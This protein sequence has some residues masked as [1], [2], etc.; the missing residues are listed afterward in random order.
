M[1]LLYRLKPEKDRVLGPVCLLLSSA[2]V[3]PN[4]VTATGLLVSAAAGVIA[5]SGN[6]SAGVAVFLIGACLDALDGSLARTSGSVSE[7]GLYLD[8]VSDRCSEAVFVTGAVIG[9]VT[10]LAITVVAGSVILL[11]SRVRNHRMG[12]GSDAAVFGRPERLALLIAGM[13]SPYPA[14]ALL[15]VVDGAA[16]VA[17]SGLVLASSAEVLPRGE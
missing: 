7:L 13:L 2:G 6:I 5:A 10:P 15:F 9:G 1:S 16:C 17:S 3:T 14:S 4:M 8:S 12:L 11:A